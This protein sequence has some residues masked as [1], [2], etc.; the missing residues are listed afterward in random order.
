MMHCL[1]ADGWFVD[2]VTTGGCDV[3]G[4]LAMANTRLYPLPVGPAKLAQSLSLSPSLAF[5]LLVWPQPKAVL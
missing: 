5:S 3:T 4:R 1:S 2:S